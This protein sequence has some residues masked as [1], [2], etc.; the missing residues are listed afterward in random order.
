[1]VNNNNGTAGRLIEIDTTTGQITVIGD[2]QIPNVDG[3]NPLNFQTSTNTV[4]ALAFRVTDW[5]EFEE[6]W[7]V[8]ADG[9]ESKLYRAASGGTTA[10]TPD[11]TANQ[12]W[13]E[14]SQNLLGYRGR[15]VLD[16]DYPTVTGV[17]FTDDVGGQLYGVTADGLLITIQPGNKV[18]DDGAPA[19]DGG[20]LI[21]FDAQAT[22]VVDFANDLATIGATGFT[23]LAAAP[24]NLHGGALKGKFFALTNNGR[25]AL[26][27]PQATT[28]E[29]V[30][31]SG[32]AGLLERTGD[33][34]GSL[35]YQGDTTAVVDLTGSPL[36]AVVQPGA[37]VNPTVTGTAQAI[38]TDTRAAVIRQVTISAAPIQ[39]GTTGAVDV[40]DEFQVIPLANTGGIEAGMLIVGEDVPFGT[41]VLD[42]ADEG[43]VVDLAFDVSGVAEGTG[44]SFYAAVGEGVG[45]VLNVN[46]DDTAEVAVPTDGLTSSLAAGM[47]VTGGGLAD[48]TTIVAIQL[49]PA[50]AA[51]RIV[52]VLSQAP[53]DPAAPL[54][55]FGATEITGIDP[56]ADGLVVGVSTLAYDPAQANYGLVI[57]KGTAVAGNSLNQPVG[58]FQNQVVDIYSGVAPALQGVKDG[59]LYVERNA[60]G[61]IVSGSYVMMADVP[62]I[63]LDYFIPQ[64]APAAVGP[65]VRGEY[66]TVVAGQGAVTATEGLNLDTIVLADV[67]G[68]VP[69]LLFIGGGIGLDQEATIL[70]VDPD[71]NT[72]Q[73]SAIPPDLNQPFWFFGVNQLTFATGLL[74]EP[75]ADVEGTGV[76]AGITVEYDFPARVDRTLGH[77]GLVSVAGGV[78]VPG[79]TA[80][81]TL[82]DLAITTADLASLEAGMRIVGESVPA[83][84]WISEVDDRYVWVAPAGVLDATFPSEELT[85]IRP[86]WSTVLAADVIG[87]LIQ[88]SVADAEGINVGML[89]SGPGFQAGTVVTGVDPATNTVTLSKRTVDADAGRPVF[90][91]LPAA[92]YLA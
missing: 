54:Q 42:I 82:A 25:L 9:P 29:W 15:I 71:T 74:P 73:L 66:Y 41:T 76:P 77:G 13:E 48:D 40:Q 26:L 58:E 18:P 34:G 27:D 44:L 53:A 33:T 11:A 23:A 70:A 7:F 37:A 22:L 35:Y 68:L 57:P 45:E 78:F 3:D 28:L 32:E 43:V 83:G 84:I 64:N 50:P 86:T 69:G 46:D 4:R 90:F 52:V 92:K 75:G 81:V 14:N 63:G 38:G 16:G 47:R 49:V 89:V 30:I 20:P 21:D 31:D 91:Y 65:A 1:G 87:G 12:G 2:D 6:L 85:F 51:D 10:G 61:E 79:Q 88:V 5:A 55:F 67:A 80:D 62:V 19:D 60:A 59:G 56:A 72:L 17:Q 8:V 36:V 39:R 24:Q